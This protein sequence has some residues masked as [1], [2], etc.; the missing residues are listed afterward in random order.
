MAE[1]L[2]KTAIA[3]TAGIGLV[4]LFFRSLDFLGDRLFCWLDFDDEGQTQPT[5]TK[6]NKSQ[7]VYRLVKQ[8]PT[9]IENGVEPMHDELA[10]RKETREQ[11]LKRIAAR[12]SWLRDMREAYR[13]E[14]IGVLAEYGCHDEG[15]ADE[16]LDGRDADQVL[17]RV[18]RSVS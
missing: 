9:W 13:K 8:E 4:W 17:T 3:F 2:T 6:P 1:E 12:G 11:Q 5:P 7:P 16:L 10:E 15:F 18:K 14:A